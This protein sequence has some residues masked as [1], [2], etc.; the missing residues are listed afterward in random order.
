MHR[1]QI[2][3]CIL[4]FATILAIPQVSTAQSQSF[5]PARPQG[6]SL[7]AIDGVLVDYAVGRSSGTFVI[8]T[9]PLGV[10]QEFYIGYPMKI[11]GRIV[12]CTVPPIDGQNADN[13]YCKDWPSN[14]LLGKTRVRVTFW[15]TKAGYTEVNVSDQIDV[16]AP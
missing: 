12:K 13:V 2:A 15:K 10:H 1:T 9:P 11:N 6:E 14:I 5:F 16:L 8:K 3:A 7:Y 4:T